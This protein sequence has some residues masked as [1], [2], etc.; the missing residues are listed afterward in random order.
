MQKSTIRI[1]KTYFAYNFSTSGFEL[2][3]LV[4][5]ERVDLKFTQHKFGKNRSRKFEIIRKSNFANANF[6]RAR[7]C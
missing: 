4:I 5:L 7:L 1:W 3:F 2:L 6:Y